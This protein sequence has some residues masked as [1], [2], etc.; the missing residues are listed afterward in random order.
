MHKINTSFHYRLLLDSN[1]FNVNKEFWLEQ[2]WR[3]GNRNIK[4]FALFAHVPIRS[5]VEGDKNSFVLFASQ[6]FQVHL[7]HKAI[8]WVNV[9]TLVLSKCLLKA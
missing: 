7:R 8:S 9:F 2:T 4:K 6:T 5:S 1:D 3:V